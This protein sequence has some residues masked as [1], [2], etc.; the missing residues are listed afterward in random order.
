MKTIKDVDHD[1]T[2][3]KLISCM[4]YH[5]CFKSGLLRNLEIP[6]FVRNDKIS[7]P[8]LVEG[9]LFK[10][11]NISAESSIFEEELVLDR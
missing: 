5:L 1:D 6:H 7:H 3:N 9:S 11:S 10:K 4:I 8:E 2:K